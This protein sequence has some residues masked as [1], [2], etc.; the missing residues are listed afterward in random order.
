M[1]VTQ[2]D[3]RRI[4]ARA[5]GDAFPVRLTTGTNVG[6]RPVWDTAPM[7]AWR[8]I[9]PG[10]TSAVCIG[11]MDRTGLIDWNANERACGVTS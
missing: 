4:I 10:K 5:Y 9:V 11:I 1:I 8:K 6:V 2:R 3:A 7:L